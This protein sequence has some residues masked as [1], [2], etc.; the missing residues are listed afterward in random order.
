[1]AY[2]AQ[3]PYPLV[4]ILPVLSIF[5]NIF[6]MFQLSDYTWLRLAAWMLL[7]AHSCNHMVLSIFSS[8]LVCVT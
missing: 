6:I 3:V 2:I 7:G 8:V 1:M 4:P 5:V